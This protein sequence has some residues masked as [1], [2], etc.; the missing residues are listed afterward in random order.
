MGVV[1]RT[2]L[3]LFIA[4]IMVRSFYFIMPEF[5]TSGVAIKSWYVTFQNYHDLEKY[6][7]FLYQPLQTQSNVYIICVLGNNRNNI[8]TH[9][10]LNDTG[11]Y[12]DAK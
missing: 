10:Y 6:R 11:I 7:H 8:L 4:I 1:L 5:Q 2:Q 3:L 9:G 12:F